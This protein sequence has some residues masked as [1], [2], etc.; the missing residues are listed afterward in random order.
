[1]TTKQ[2]TRPAI[3]VP[4]LT[5]ALIV[6]AVGLYLFQPWKLFVDESVDEAAPVAVAQSAGEPAAAGGS[7]GA[8]QSEDPVILSSGTFI[9][10]E[11][12]TTGSV[13]ILQ[14]PDGSRVL[15]IEDLDTS[16]GPDL[17]VGGHHPAPRLPRIVPAAGRQRVSDQLPPGLVS[18]V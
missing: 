14:L 12:A 2:L 8:A 11:H 6:G 1:M 10:H 9:S 13:Q 15:R 16:N 17:K 7:A 18:G 4:L 5:V 3:L